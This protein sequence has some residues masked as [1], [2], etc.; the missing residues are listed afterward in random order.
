MWV[1]AY[2]VLAAMLWS[3]IGVATV[4]GRNLLLTLLIRS[5]VAS[6]IS[7]AL[8]RSKYKASIVCGT[9]L[10]VLF[11]V[12]LT[13]VLLAGVGPAAYLLYTAPLWTSLI[14]LSYGESLSRYSVLAISFILTAV[15]L[16]GLE[17]L[18]YGTLTLPG[19]FSGLASSIVYGTYISLVRYYSSVGLDREVSLGA[20]PYTLLPIIPLATIYSV[21][22]PVN[23]I[24]IQH[25][26]IAGTYLAIFCTILPYRLFSM[27][28]RRLKASTASVL[29]S[30]E[31]VF[32]CIWDYIFFS[33]T[34]TVL[35][36]V[37]YSFISL[38]SILVSLEKSPK[39]S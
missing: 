18:I 31:P 21:L 14:A 6:L 5:I 2:V 8:V 20:I 29:A 27:G 30:I 39:R 19:F 7:L 10:G 26:M 35:Q 3:T 32:A 22:E 23:F 24:Y 33:N 11:V 37:A 36:W 1:S 13:S 4:Y 38:A 9:V 15:S 28:A 34:P 25:S 16:M 17:S 12:Y